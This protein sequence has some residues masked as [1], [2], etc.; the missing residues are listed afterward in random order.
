MAPAS[1]RATWRCV[2]L[3]IL[4]DFR[5][6]V[7]RKLQGAEFQDQLRRVIPSVAACGDKA[8]LEEIPALGEPN[9]DVDI[10][11]RNGWIGVDV[12]ASYRFDDVQ[13]LLEARGGGRGAQTNLTRA[14]PTAWS[15]Y[16]RA[17]TIQIS[18]DCMTVSLEGEAFLA[19]D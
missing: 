6:N 17:A 11:S 3:H 5:A 12:A 4:R 10:P 14:R 16:D 13:A 8:F 9:L 2:T 7:V 18:E 19:R 15:R 1:S